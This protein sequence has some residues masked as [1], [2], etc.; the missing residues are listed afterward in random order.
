[1]ENISVT[2]ML[3]LIQT[4]EQIE[5]LRQIRNECRHFMT[6]N[7]NEISQT[8]QL[9]WY[10]LLDKEKNKLYLF[11]E[12]YHGVSSPGPIG[13]GVIKKED[14]CILLTGGLLSKERNKGFG[15]VLFDMLVKEAK[16][17]NLPIKLEVLKSNERAKHIYSKL[18]FRSEEHT[19]ELQSH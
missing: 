14:D 7:T 13:Y 15:T 17:Q 3:I 5:N 19:S 16:K 6:R 9:D 4:L 8:E 12:N 11:Y 10:N 1:M 2:Y 18:G